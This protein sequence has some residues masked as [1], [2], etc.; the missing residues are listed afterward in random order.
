MFV[1]Y[2]GGNGT[3]AVSEAA[4]GGGGD[5][6]SCSALSC[7]SCGGGCAIR[8][9]TLTKAVGMTHEQPLPPAVATAAAAKAAAVGATAAHDPPCEGPGSG[10]SSDSLRPPPPLSPASATS[11]P[12]PHGIALGPGF[13]FRPSK[14]SA[15]VAALS[16]AVSAKYAALKAGLSPA[17]VVKAAAPAAAVAAGSQPAAVSRTQE[18]QEQADE[19]AARHGANSAS[20]A[21]AAVASSAAAAVA[22]AAGGDGSGGGGDVE[23]VPAPLRAAAAR[24][25]AETQAATA[26]HRLQ[27]LQATGVGASVAA[28]LSSGGGLSAGGPETEGVSAVAAAA[29]AAATAA[30][31]GRESRNSGGGI[32]A[33]AAAAA[34]GTL[35]GYEDSS[36]T[37]AGKAFPAAASAPAASA[38]PLSSPSAS[39]G[40][41]SGSYSSSMNSVSMSSSLSAGPAPRVAHLADLCP[42]SDRG[43]SSLGLWMEAARAVAHAA[44]RLS[45]VADGSDGVSAEYRSVLACALQLCSSCPLLRELVLRRLLRRWPAG[46]SD[47]EVALLE[48]LATVLGGVSHRADLVVTDLRGALLARLLRCLRSPH[49]KVAR[50]AL[51]LCDP[52]RRLITFLVDEPGALRQLLDALAATSRSHWSPLAR[53]A[54]SETYAAYLGEYEA[55]LRA[56]GRH[57]PPGLLT[58]AGAAALAASARGRGVAIDCT[59]KQHMSPVP[60]AQQQHLHLHHQQLSAASEGREGVVAIGTRSLRPAHDDA[61]VLAAVAA[62]AATAQPAESRP[63]PISAPPQLQQP[64]SPAAGAAGAVPGSSGSSTDSEVTPPAA[65]AVTHTL[66]MAKDDPI[67]CSSVLLHCRPGSERGSSPASSS[68][69]CTSDSISAS[70]AVPPAGVAILTVPP[71]LP[72]QVGRDATATASAAAASAASSYDYSRSVRPLQVHHHPILGMSACHGHGSM[73][74][75]SP[76]EFHMRSPSTD[77]ALLHSARHARSGGGGSSSARGSAADQAQ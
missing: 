58:A 44:V 39:P 72:P 10:S 71:L 24:A 19:A 4:A 55:R 27:L 7:A 33:A 66:L 56:L 41:G 70:S 12:R 59:P 57:M 26:K 2:G 8:L 64:V 13:M 62:A 40:G 21:R 31:V 5:D 76:A 51:V 73:P 49:I 25:A 36:P 29:A 15:E 45:A 11:A 22:A 1:G 37:A 65:P 48:F 30:V 17:E 50:T 46:H 18:Y 63:P 28:A 47:N 54:A 77:V 23:S 68:G 61:A 52:K 16:E 35:L 67:D 53:R 43:G 69:T 60:K 32:A 9:S 14:P 38:G 6:E 34:G 75:D 74:F 42:S 20:S 3:A